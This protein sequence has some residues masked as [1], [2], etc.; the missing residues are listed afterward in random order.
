MSYCMILCGPPGTGKTSLAKALC[1]RGRFVHLDKDELQPH[2]D[3]RDPE[4]RDQIRPKIYQQ[5]AKLAGEHLKEGESVIIDAPFLHQFD[6]EG[7]IESFTDLLPPD[8]QISIYWLQAGEETIKQRIAGRGEERDLILQKTGLDNW[9]KEDQYLFEAPGG[10]EVISTEG[11]SA[12]QIAEAMIA[13][14]DY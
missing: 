12:E 6:E 9:Y 7:G 14:P 3:T 1:T 5:M 2:P 10:I 4:Y 11:Q 13:P 8:T